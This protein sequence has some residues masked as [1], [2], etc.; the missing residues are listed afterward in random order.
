MKT[1]LSLITLAI[2]S[3]SALAIDATTLPTGEKIRSGEATFNRDGSAM[4]INQSSNRVSI[5]WD[6]FNIGSKASVEFKQPSS[7]SIAYN[8]V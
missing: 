2:I 4:T 5:D 7:S 6:S 1:S 3:T 8:R